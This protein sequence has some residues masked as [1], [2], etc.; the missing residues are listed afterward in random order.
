MRPSPLRRHRNEYICCPPDNEP[1]FWQ[2][3]RQHLDQV[4]A[5]DQERTFGPL[6]DRLL[7][8]S[9]G[10]E[11]HGEVEARLMVRRIAGHGVGQRAERPGIL[12]L[13]GKVERAS[14][15]EDQPATAAVAVTVT[16]AVVQQVAAGESSIAD[17]RDL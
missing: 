7:L 4:E 15:L 3:A 16:A 6:I 5:A 8:A 13:D 9:G 1:A 10:I 14:G 11:R 12:G 17:F 2:A